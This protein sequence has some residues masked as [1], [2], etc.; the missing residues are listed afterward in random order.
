MNTFG[1]VGG[2]LIA[3]LG[4]AVIDIGINP[5]NKFASQAFSLGV[6]GIAVGGVIVWSSNRKPAKSILEQKYQVESTKVSPTTNDGKYRILYENSPVMQRTVDTNGII[7][8]CNQT[9]VKNFGNFKSDVIGKSLIDHTAEKSLADMR[10]TFETWKATGKVDNAEIWFKRK[11]GTTFPGLISANN[12]HDEKGRLIGSNTVIRD[13]SETYQARKV[14]EENERRGIQLEELSKMERL[15]NDFYI[16]VSKEFQI[17]IEPIKKY[18]DMLKD[19]A[20]GKLNAKQREAIS[21]I[22]SN[23]V[24]LEQLIQDIV[25][26]QKLDSKRMEFQKEDFRV[27][28]FMKE[29]VNTCSNMMNEKNIEFVDMNSS[30]SVIKSDKSRLAQVFYNLI[31]NAIDFV[32]REGG[33][34][35]ISAQDKGNSFL[36][37]VK[38]NGIGISE[39]RKDS[40]FKKFYQVDISLKRRYGGSGFGLVICKGIVENLG[41]KIWFESKEAEGTTF[42]F[43]IPK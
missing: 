12:I 36:F 18:C 21:E 28:E 37:Y 29:I 30:N 6:A 16:T 23:A 26:V 19:S 34:I 13:I 31:Q 11:D 17:P 43:S 27:D 41:G 25:D 5:E 7:I 33:R 39:K 35:E 3:V 40:I 24:R 9:Y 42:Y 1:T 22:Y 20:I 2:L 15:K 10:R 4:L 32:P 8:E 38:D 14:L